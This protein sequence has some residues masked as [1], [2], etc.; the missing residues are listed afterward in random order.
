MADH[1]DSTT[2]KT[3]GLF[4]DLQTK[5]EDVTNQVKDINKKV[6]DGKLRTVKGIGFLEV[7]HQLL[8][9]YLVNLTHL[10]L[11]RSSGKSIQNLQDIHHLIEIRTV[12]ERIRPIDQKLK[13]QID[14]LVKT[15]ITGSMN[16]ND[17]LRFKPNP[18]NLVS[19][20]N[21]EDSES[22]T[23]EDEDI[24]SNRSKIYL[25]PKLAAVY[26]DGDMTVKDRMNMKLDKAKKRAL[27]SSIMQELREEY[28]TAPREIKESRDLYRLKVDKEAKE[29]EVY[30]ED[31]FLRLSLTKQQRQSMKKMTT[32]SS[33]NSLTRFDDIS[34]LDK[35]ELSDDGVT[36]K[37]KRPQ[38]HTGKK[39]G[40][41]KRKF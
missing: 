35:D 20:L 31:N 11:Q 41:K 24:K 36:K 3:L 15:A 33:L 12:L 10:M 19:K 17:P 38:K 26:Y 2:A 39:G 25:P 27:S 13:Y 6:D 4:T 34:A 7:K 18:N 8:L 37:R 5:L 30:E 14:K 21:D 40:K 23:D 28:D 9:S 1:D 16:E 32:M 29:R 22:D